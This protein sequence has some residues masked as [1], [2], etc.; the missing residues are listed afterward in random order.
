LKEQ[1]FSAVQQ[2]CGLAFEGM[3]AAMAG[4]LDEF[5]AL[6]VKE[7]RGWLLEYLVDLLGLSCDL[8]SLHPGRDGRSSIVLS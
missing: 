2:L 6:K 3:K 5:P 7:E 8:L 4:L 1:A